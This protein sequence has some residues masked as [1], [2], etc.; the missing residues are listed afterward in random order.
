MTAKKTIVIRIGEPVASS[1]GQSVPVYDRRRDIFLGW[2]TLLR[3][4]RTWSASMAIPYLRNELS[5]KGELGCPTLDGA[6]RKL[7]RQLRKHLD[8]G[9]WGLRQDEKRR[10]AEG[11]GKELAR[12]DKRRAKITETLEG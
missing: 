1:T 12:L 11:L 10:E 4:S 3:G 5:R 2:L 9:W 6:R 7:N 8:G